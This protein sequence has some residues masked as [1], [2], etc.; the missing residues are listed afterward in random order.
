[1]GKFYAS[2][3]K[4]ERIMNPLTLPSPSRERGKR[5]FESY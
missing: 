3:L 4:L 1:M 2:L 5:K